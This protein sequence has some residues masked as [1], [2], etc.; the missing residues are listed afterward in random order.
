MRSSWDRMYRQS[1]EHGTE[2]GAWQEVQGAL[3][4]RG[5]SDGWADEVRP[6]HQKAESGTTRRCWG[7]FQANV[8][9]VNHFRFR[10]LLSF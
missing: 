3:R 4:A 1:L 8:W 2:R 6:S 7:A 10:L 9:P 5:A